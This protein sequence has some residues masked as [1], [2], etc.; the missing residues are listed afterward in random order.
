MTSSLSTP[1]SLPASESADR[2][3]RTH[4][5][6]TDSL[7][8]SQSKPQTTDRAL[9]GTP[10]NFT[11]TLEPRHSY[12]LT[13]P[14][15]RLCARRIMPG[16]TTRENNAK[17]L[18]KPESHFYYNNISIRVVLHIYLSIQTSGLWLCL[19]LR[20]QRAVTR[21]ACHVL[22]TD[23]QSDIRKEIPKLMQKFA[24]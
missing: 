16:K 9:P 15:L 6:G 11:E 17:A 10:P 12:Q 24:N 3:R 2:S 5:R 13:P 1:S 14:S 20:I 8:C 22:E 7:Q 19:Y 4:Y 18:Q 21:V 23:G